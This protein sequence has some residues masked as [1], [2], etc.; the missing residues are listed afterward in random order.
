MR[1]NP[2]FYVV[3]IIEHKDNTFTPYFCGCFTECMSINQIQDCADIP[4]RV[5]SDIVSVGVVGVA[6]TRK[7][8]EKAAKEALND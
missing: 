7:K 6:P 3:L 5:F 4:F 8:A 2:D 1:K